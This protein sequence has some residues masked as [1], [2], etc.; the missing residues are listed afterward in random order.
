M[1]TTVI[2]LSILLF[3]ASCEIMPRNTLKDC[4]QQCKDSKKSQACYD[5]CDCIHKDGKPLDTCLEAYE[6]A[7]EDSTGLVK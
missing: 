1:R 2:S 5:F 6:Q 3:A 4:R 7:P